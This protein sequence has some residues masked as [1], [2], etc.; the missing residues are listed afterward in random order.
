MGISKARVSRSLTHTRA[1]PM[2]P[3]SIECEE[4]FNLLGVFN[5]RSTGVKDVKSSET[6]RGHF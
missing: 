3:I 4:A 1:R 2:I 5:S 6:F